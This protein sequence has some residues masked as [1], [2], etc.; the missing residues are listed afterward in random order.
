MKNW[1]LLGWEW[2]DGVL[3]GFAP[4]AFHLLL[5]QDEEQHHASGADPRHTKQSYSRPMKR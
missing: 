1:I 3:V 4:C 2:L 5:P